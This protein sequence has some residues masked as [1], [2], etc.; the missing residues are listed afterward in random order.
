MAVTILNYFDADRRSVSA[1]EAMTIG[2]VVKV[3]V[4]GT[5][6][7]VTKLGDADDAL[8]LP[9]NVGVVF[10]VSTDPNQVVESAASANAAV[11]GDRIPSIA[12]GD[13]VVI[14][15]AGTIIEYNASEL[16]DSLNPDAAGVLPTV[17]QDLGVSGSKFATI[18]AA[19]AAGIAS[20]VI[21]R[22]YQVIG[23]KV[24]VELV[25]F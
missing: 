4:S 25:S 10:K 8:A 2:D 16:D 19:T 6:R 12:S 22:C 9:G 13:A 1:G 11:T 3:V 20:P 7:S 18:A 23:S 21:A 14:C 15:R 24:A 17:G 5:S